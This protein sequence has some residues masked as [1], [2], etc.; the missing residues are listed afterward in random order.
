MTLAYTLLL[1]LIAS[2]YVIASNN[3]HWFCMFCFSIMVWAILLL[4]HRFFSVT[5]GV[6]WPAR[7]GW[8]RTVEAHGSTACPGSGASDCRPARTASTR[9]WTP[10]QQGPRLS[11]CMSAKWPRQDHKKN[12]LQKDSHMDVKGRNKQVAIT[13]KTFN[14]LMQDEIFYIFMC[15]KSK[16]IFQKNSVS[17]V[18]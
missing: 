5:G 4:F 15:G 16:N 11:R 1:T 12:Q 8:C 10:A 3:A 17:E 13:H 9:C 2:V 6:S 14:V 18:K 7:W